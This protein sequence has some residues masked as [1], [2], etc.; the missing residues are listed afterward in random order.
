MLLRVREDN[1]SS[2]DQDPQLVVTLV[3]EGRSSRG[4][5][6]QQN[7]EC[8]PVDSERV[9]THVK[10][11]RSQVLSCATE[12]ESLIFWLEEFGEAK[13]RQTDV[14]IEIHEH[15]LRFQV[16]MDDAPLVQIAKGKNNLGPNEFDCGFSKATNLVNIVV[17]VATWEVLEEEVDL[18]FVL[19]DEVHRVDEWVVRLEQNVFLVLDVLDLLLLQQE[20]LVDALHGVHLSHLAVRDQEH[21]TEAA[22]VNDFYDF[23]IVKCDDLAF[24]TWLA[25]QTHALSLVFLI[26]LLGQVL[27]RV[28]LFHIRGLQ[29]DKVIKE[30]VFETVDPLVSHFCAS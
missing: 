25:D 11:L 20:V 17:N 9:A 29:D 21:F 14:A 8:P 19:E 15:V 18:E 27:G 2:A 13:V 6:V 3:E 4:H 30:L 7:A 28:V 24:E 1:A 26:V 10:N 22:F 5:L 12:G 16:A 23:E